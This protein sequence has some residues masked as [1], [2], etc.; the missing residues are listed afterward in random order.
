MSPNPVVSD[1]IDV[2]PDLLEVHHNVTL[3]TDVMFVSKIPFFVTVSQNIK[4]FTGQRLPDRKKGTLVTALLKV[5]NLYRRRGFSIQV[6]NMDNEFECLTDTMQKRKG[7]VPLNI[8]AKEEHVPAIERGIQTMK[9]RIRGAITTLPYRKIP[10]VMCV[11]LVLFCILMLN[12]F[13]PIGGAST[14][15]A[16]QTIMKGTALD[17][18]VHCRV[19]FGAYAQVHTH[20]TPTNNAT[21]SRTVGGIALG[22]TGNKQGTYRFMSLETGRKITGNAFDVLPM[23]VDVIK[24]VESFTRIESL[25]GI[26]IGDRNGA[27]T[28]RLSIDDINLDAP[29]ESDDDDFDD[30]SSAISNSSHDS[31]D[32]SLYF[33]ADADLTPA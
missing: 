6:C 8:C 29:E 16:P 33:D 15:F 32:E 28:E 25:P 22:P 4:F 24:K 20:T 9:G 12:M 14:S 11:N 31:S 23:P 5:A 1:Y 7:G 26:A 30:Y 19:P 2:P 27:Q 21:V 17:A 18:K 10:R 13:P 3:A